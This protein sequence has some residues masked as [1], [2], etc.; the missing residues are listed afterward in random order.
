MQPLLIFPIS[1]PLQALMPGLWVSDLP[2]YSEQQGPVYITFG[3]TE[4]N[5]GLCFPTHGA[6]LGIWH[7]MC[8]GSGGQEEWMHLLETTAFPE[9]AH[10]IF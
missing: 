8:S 6:Q 10:L 7:T 1:K 5:L 4:L 9:I 3:K 2:P